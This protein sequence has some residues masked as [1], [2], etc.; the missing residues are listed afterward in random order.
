MFGTNFPPPA[1]LLALALLVGIWLL[2]GICRRLPRLIGWLV[3]GWTIWRLRDPRQTQALHT[4]LPLLIVG[5]LAL[6][7]ATARNGRHSG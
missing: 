2:I 1:L 3:A 7:V 5:W 4:L 6:R